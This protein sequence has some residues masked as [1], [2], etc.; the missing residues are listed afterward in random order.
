[1]RDREVADFLR[2]ALSPHQKS[3]LQHWTSMGY[4][5]RAVI[6]RALNLLDRI[7]FD[8]Q[9]AILK[10]PSEERLRQAARRRWAKVKR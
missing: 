10:R 5:T 9:P 3:V 1:M 7:D 6:G 8:E 4:S 2:D